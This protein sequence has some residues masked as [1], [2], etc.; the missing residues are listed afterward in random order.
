MTT[1]EEVK[2]TLIYS[3]RQGRRR[4]T[5]SCSWQSKWFIQDPAGQYALKRKIH[6]H[7]TTRKKR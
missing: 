7:M 5:C 6:E 4:A 3:V 2:H 1:E